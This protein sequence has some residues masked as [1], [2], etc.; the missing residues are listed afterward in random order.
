MSWK[1]F[2][3]LEA[4]DEADARKS[5]R[6]RLRALRTPEEIQKD[7]NELT[8]RREANSALVSDYRKRHPESFKEKDRRILSLAKAERDK[9]KIEFDIQRITTK[10]T[11][12]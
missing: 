9:M 12:H 5:E 6:V 11:S 4:I 2:Y 10:A 7:E 1:G 3:E 8:L